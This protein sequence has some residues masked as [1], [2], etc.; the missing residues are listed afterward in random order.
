MVFKEIEEN[1]EKVSKFIL[2][3]AGERGP[4]ARGLLLFSV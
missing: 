4:T 2:G 3:E 1:Y